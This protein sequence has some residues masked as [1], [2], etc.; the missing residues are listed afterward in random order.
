MDPI[1]LLQQSLVD[2]VP[3]TIMVHWNLLWS[4]R[5]FQNVTKIWPNF[6]TTHHWCLAWSQCVCGLWRVVRPWSWTQ[7]AY[8][9]NHCHWWIHCLIPSWCTDIYSGQGE[10]FRIRPKSGLTFWPHIIDVCYVP[11]VYVAC[12]GL[13]DLG[14]GPNQ[15]MATIIAE[16]TASYHHGAL[17][18]TLVR[19]RISGFG[20]NLA[21]FLATHH[22][23]L[24]WT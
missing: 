10:N 7:Q 12:E 17:M 15:P 9:N 22:W 14:I 20:K 5:E 18:F 3:H 6:L 16:Y 4:G 21:R 2:T 8:C 24:A 19:V 11:S 1:G 13:S 23:C